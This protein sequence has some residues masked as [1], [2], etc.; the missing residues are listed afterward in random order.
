M[1][2]K[3]LMVVSILFFSAWQPLSSSADD[4]KSS[5]AGDARSSSAGDTK[6]A[7]AGDSKPATETVPGS[8]DGIESGTAPEAAKDCHGPLYYKLKEQDRQNRRAESYVG[9][10]EAFVKRTSQVLYPAQHKEFM[11]LLEGQQKAHAQC[12]EEK[13]QPATFCLA[14]AR[15]DGSLCEY[16]TSLEQREWC[17]H[18]LLAYEAVTTRSA[19][20]CAKINLE[21]ERA[22]CEFVVVGDFNCKRLAGEMAAACEALAAGIAGKPLPASIPDDARVALQWLIA[23]KRQETTACDALTEV[24]DRSA[25]QALLNADPAVCPKVRGLEEFIDQDFSCRKPVV[26]QA[27]HPAA[28]GNL[29]ALTVASAILGPGNCEVHLDLLEDGRK[30]TMKGGEVALDGM[31]N[32]KHFHLFTGKGRLIDV[33][34]ACQWKPPGESPGGDVR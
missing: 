24:A 3:F 23:V 18:L 11:Q 15:R 28:W 10:M 31:G 14:M 2:R 12:L 22:M 25:C 6:S 17:N 8:P 1:V 32:Y 13:E 21:A 5:G 26:Y 20:P 19:A 34:V 9:E 30:R 29:V 27:E 16:E 7:T 4:A 33:R